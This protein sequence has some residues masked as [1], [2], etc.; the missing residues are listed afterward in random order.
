MARSLSL[1]GIAFERQ[2]D[3]A[4]PGAH[5]AR[6]LEMKMCPMPADYTMPASGRVEAVIFDLGG[7][8]VESPFETAIRWGAEWDLPREVF[9]ILYAEYSAV[10][11]AGEVVPLWHQVETGRLSL[12]AYVEHLQVE[13]DSLLPKDHPGRNLTADDFNLFEGAALLEPVI[14]VASRLTDAGTPISILT[15]NVAEWASWRDVVP[16]DMFVDVVDSCEVGLRKP[17]PA[18]YQLACERLRAD[19]GAVLFV[20]DHAGNVEAARGLGLGGLVMGD[21]VGPAVAILADIA[22]TSSS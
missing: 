10:P 18:M 17:D 11:E 2:G 13:F 3:R 9:E 22:G 7:V 4:P 8:L 6:R 5:P 21:D 16:L 1:D 20:D 15:N 19:P 12:Q 14:E